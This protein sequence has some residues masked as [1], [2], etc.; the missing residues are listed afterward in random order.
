M[1]HN[2]LGLIIARRKFRWPGKE[3]KLCGLGTCLTT[4]ALIILQ[5]SCDDL[6]H[7]PDEISAE[8]NFKSITISS[9]EEDIKRLLGEPKGRIVCDHAHNTYQSV[10]S[11]NHAAVTKHHR[12][13]ALIGSHPQELRFLP[14][15]K[16]CAKILVYLDATVHAYFYLGQDG[17]LEDRIIE[18]S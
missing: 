16:R 6:I 18:I 12:L 15:E 2:S 17:R 13:D 11:A 10:T 7:H 5:V 4:L 14:P 3:G 9:T 1:K 8:K